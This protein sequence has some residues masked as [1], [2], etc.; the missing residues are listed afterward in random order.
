MGQQRQ[1]RDEGSSAERIARLETAL[2][3]EQLMTRQA[4]QSVRHRLH[5]LEQRSETSQGYSLDT[6]GM[7]KLAIAVLLPLAVLVVTGSV[8]KA[9]VAYRAVAG[10]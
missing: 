10:L 3:Y 6:A 2:Y 8:D 5:L 9:V 1:R 4:L 7:I